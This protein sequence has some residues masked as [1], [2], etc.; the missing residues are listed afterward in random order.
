MDHAPLLGDRDASA[1]PRR[2]HSGSTKRSVV[3]VWEH[4]RQAVQE[5]LL[6]SASSIQ[7]GGHARFYNDEPTDVLSYIS[8]IMTHCFHTC[9]ACASSI[10]AVVPTPP[11]AS[12]QTSTAVAEHEKVISC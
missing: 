10:R 2:S 4:R 12:A 8:C 6:V 11:Q 9:S 7:N 1:G 3:P 5:R